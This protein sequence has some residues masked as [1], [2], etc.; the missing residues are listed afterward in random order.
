MIRLVS[1]FLALCI[2]MMASAEAAQAQTPTPTPN[3]TTISQL[4]EQE[5]KPPL[6]NTN[7]SP[8]DTKSV[9][10]LSNIEKGG[11]K[12]HFMGERS[13]LYGWLI[14]KDGQVQMIYVTPDRK[15]A[16]I[17]GMFTS[18]GDN[19]TGQQIIA[20]GQINKEVA[21]ILNGPAKQQEELNK[22]NGITGGAPITGNNKA[23]SAN[24]SPGER[25]FRDL[26]AANGVILGKNDRAEIMMVMDPTCPH[27]KAT[28]K[29]LRDAVM[30]NRVQV[31]LIP[32]TNDPE[33]DNTRA[34]ARLLMDPNPLETWERYVNGDKNVLNGDVEQN[35]IEAIL[36]NNQL[37]EKWNIRSTPYLAYRAKDGKVKIV[38]GKPERMA[39][40]LSDL[41]M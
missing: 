10:I 39:T 16:L 13:G 15:T 19:V 2:F 14:V 33:S 32:V 34:G 1:S 12:L 20:L 41:M 6:Y 31:R 23:L 8:P 17:G 21:D 7:V 29:E 26:Q 5:A 37:I 3:R 35:R 9:P 28:W 4:M 36:L 27:C 11:A 38:Q 22:I 18:E 24:L 25:L 30:A 40:V